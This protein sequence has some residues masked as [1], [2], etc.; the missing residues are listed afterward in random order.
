MIMRVY[1]YCACF[2][3]QAEGYVSDTSDG[4][5]FNVCTMY[6]YMYNVLYSG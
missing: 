4:E 6:M 2:P 1:M 3:L 5:C